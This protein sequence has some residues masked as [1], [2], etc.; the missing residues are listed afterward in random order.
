MTLKAAIDT[1]VKRVLSAAH[2]SKIILFGSRA[3]GAATADSDL[4]LLVVERQ[5]AFKI[6]EMARLR[7]A[8]GDIGLSVDILVCSEKEIADWGELPGTAI[9]WALKEGKVLYDAAR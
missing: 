7:K 2:P 5:V 9:Y 3:K 4:D 6:K 8:V 1:A